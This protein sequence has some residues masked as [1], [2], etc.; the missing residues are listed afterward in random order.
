MALRTVRVLLQE[1]VAL[2]EYG[3]AVE[4]FGIDRTADGVPAFDYAEVTRTPERPLRANNG[5]RLTVDRGLDDLV[6]ADLV[7]I[8]AV[9]SGAAEALEA[10]HPDV[11]AA[12]RAAHER[13]AILLTVCS[14][15]FTLAAAGLLDGLA[16]ATHWHLSDQLQAE[17]PQLTVRADVLYIDAGSIITSAGTAAGIDA[18]LHLV[19][20]ELGA[21]V[22]ARIARRMVVPPHRDGGQQQFV[23]LPVPACSDDSLARLLDSVG[24]R[25]DQDHSVDSL[26]A[27][28]M[29]SP[30]TFARRFRAEVGTTPALWLSRQRVIAAR[31]LLE[32]SDLSVE[33]VADRVGFGSSVVLRDHFR[34]EV[35]VPP[36]AYRRSFAGVR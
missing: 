18:C 16:C 30:R 2:F 14:G 10:P 7:V 5:V 21:D 25:L 9:S 33:Q 8:P 6:G 13:G 28:A 35:G 27:E 17:F 26:A 12:V 3:I 32:A 29:M 34:R 24:R 15:V 11:I 23:D 31:Q 36:Q 20:R 19:R 1:P 22:A 4:V